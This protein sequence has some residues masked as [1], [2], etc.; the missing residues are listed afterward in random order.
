M[1]ALV[2]MGMGKAGST[3]LQKHIFS[4]LT[5]IYNVPETLHLDSRMMDRSLGRNGDAVIDS[6]SK[7]QRPF[8]YSDES[9]IGWFP[10]EF[11]TALSYVDKSD[12]DCSWMLVI[13]DPLEYVTSLYFQM[14]RFGYHLTV[15]EFEQYVLKRLVD[16]C[17][18]FERL[19]AIGE[20]S[21]ITVFS[22]KEVLDMTY[23]DFMDSIKI[24]KLSIHNDS[25]G[26][27]NFIISSLPRENTGFGFF[28]NLLS[29]S[30]DLFPSKSEYDNNRPELKYSRLSRTSLFRK[31][32]KITQMC[33]GGNMKINFEKEF[34]SIMEE[35]SVGLEKIYRGLKS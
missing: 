27:G 3:L 5:P 18:G 10:N 14:R 24:S 1:D 31:I 9:L 12:F 33:D 17:F 25:N 13:R 4:R 16:D 15:K 22:L 35:Q 23:F 34:I 20:N 19:P 21:K 29:E 2:H 6:L 28:S 30:L 26:D 11:E 7:L 8:V 32:Q